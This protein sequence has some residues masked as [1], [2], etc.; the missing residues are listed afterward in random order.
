MKDALRG[1]IKGISILSKPCGIAPDPVVKRKNSIE[2]TARLV[3]LVN[4]S[5]ASALFGQT[6]VTIPNG[7]S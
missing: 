7:V 4:L 2:L 5:L 3:L 6:S 1:E